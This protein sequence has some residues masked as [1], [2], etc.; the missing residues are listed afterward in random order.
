MRQNQQF[1]IKNLWLDFLNYAII[2]L[3]IFSA[4]IF[5]IY[6]LN[7]FENHQSLV[8]IISLNAATLL[9][10]AFSIISFVHYK[11][12]STS[13]IIDQNSITIPIGLFF[14]EKQTILFDH[15]IFENRYS[16]K[17]DEIYSIVYNGGSIEMRKSSLKFQTDWKKLVYELKEVI[18]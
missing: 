7:L 12:T 4:F 1:E 9:I 10:T 17:G 15:I 2:T 5:S 13:I 14:P 16:S 6:T 18:H 8:I 11:S 3:I